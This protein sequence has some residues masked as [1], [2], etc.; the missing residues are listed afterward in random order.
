LHITIHTAKKAQQRLTRKSIRAYELVSVISESGGVEVDLTNSFNHHLTSPEK[1]LRRRSENQPAGGGSSR[2]KLAPKP[3]PQNF[4]HSKKARKQAKIYSSKS[5]R[6]FGGEKKKQP[7]ANV[8][9]GSAA[10]S[11][12][13]EAH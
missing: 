12:A 1:P 8:A 9:K 11:K 13:A 7:G 4:T 10:I 2:S 5:T 6:S 3:P